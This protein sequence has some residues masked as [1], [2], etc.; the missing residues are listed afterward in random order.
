MKQLSVVGTLCAALCLP[1]LSAHAV[2]VDRGGG[3]LYD[4]VLNITW[5]Q[6]ANYAKTSGYC[7]TAGTCTGG[8]YG[9]SL[10]S[11]QMNWTQANTWANNLNYGGYSSGWRLARN[12]PVNGT[13]SGW[14]YDPTNDGT[15]DRG[16]NI[17]ST[18]SELSYMYYVNLSL[19]GAANPDGSSRSDYGVNGNGSSGGQKDV[20]LVRNLQSG[21]YWSSTA[22]APAPA[23]SAWFF[24]T[25][26]GHQDVLFQ[27]GGYF[28]WAVRDGDVTVAAVPVPGSV[29]LLA[30]GLA[31]LGVVTRRRERSAEGKR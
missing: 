20:G 25:S 24:G 17:T 19:K 6:D 28:A 1:S 15:A 7:S 21:V 26:D 30:G 8:I 13:Q 9:E 18:F 16:Y 11:G 31:L 5:L 23:V 12:T 3:M 10:Y 14:N 4:T 22:Y 2:L 29:A 27:W